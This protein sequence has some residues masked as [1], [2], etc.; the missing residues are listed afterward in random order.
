MGVQDF[1]KNS[2]CPGFSVGVQDFPKISP[3]DFSEEQWVSKISAKISPRFLEEQWVSKISPEEQWV[4]KI[5]PKI[6]LRGRPRIMGC[7][8]LRFVG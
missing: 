8:E 3:Q 7:D 4:S 5:S 1:L 2:G 6:S